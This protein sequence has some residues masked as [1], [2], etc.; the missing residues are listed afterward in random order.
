MKRKL[1]ARPKPY[2]QHG[3]PSRAR[4]P[5][6]RRLVVRLGPS[7][8]PLQASRDVRC[9]E[10]LIECGRRLAARDA[11]PATLA[12]DFSFIRT[13]LTHAAAVHSIEV[14]IESDVTARRA[15]PVAVISLPLLLEQLSDHRGPRG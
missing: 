1:T 10:K 4:A 11:G 8:T 3:G 9:C 12:V 7:R 15:W 13:V 14:S 2:V 5:P 6:R